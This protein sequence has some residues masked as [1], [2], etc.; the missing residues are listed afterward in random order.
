MR[1]TGKT[2]AGETGALRTEGGGVTLLAASLLAPPR[3]IAKDR[4]VLSIAP[5]RDLATLINTYR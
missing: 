2:L 1:L 5:R 4:R 3:S